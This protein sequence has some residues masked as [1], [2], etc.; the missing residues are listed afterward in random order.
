M[1]QAT[2][3]LV[4]TPDRDG[5]YPRLTDDQIARLAAEGRRRHVVAGEVLFREGDER[6]DFY[7][8]L[9]GRVAMVDQF[10]LP[11]ERVI[12]V[13]G[14]RRFLGE[15]GLLT[16]QAAFYTAVV[17]EP[18][19]VLVVPVQRLS[20]LVTQDVAL[21]DVVLRA[22][23]VRRELLIGLGAGFRVIGSRFSPDARR[24][25]E[26]AARNR[27][28][29]RWIDL[30]EDQAAE[31]LLR[32]L[33]VAPEETP[34]VIWNRQVLRNPSN[35]DLGREIGL[36]V[37][38]EPRA[39]CDL[40]VVG[41]GPAGLAAAVYGASEGLD[42]VVLDGVAT[43]GQA[44]TSS[45]IENYLG[46]PA[47]ISGA[48]LAERA[49]IQARKFGGRL[50]VPSEAVAAQP[51]DG[52][53]VVRLDDGA[54]ICAR[55]M[56]VATG[57][58]YRR[59]D[60]PGLDRLEGDSVYYAATLMEARVCAGD[61]VAVVG[62]GNSAGQAALFL[63]RYA[64]EVHVLVRGHSLTADMS[65]Y[66]A[67]RIA[68]EPRVSVMLQTEIRELDGDATLEAVIAEDRARGRR[69]RIPA[70][71]LFVFIGAE[72]HT[73]WLGGLVAL[74]PNGFVL[75]GADARESAANG[76]RSH[77]RPRLLLETS[78]PGVLAVGDVRSG[79][80]KRVASAVGEGAMAV[81]L[82]HEHLDRLHGHPHHAP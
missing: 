13:H 22:Y 16:G 67:D 7:V 3:Q 79:S 75:T 18:G 33:G 77:S 80:I 59:L 5:A 35:E 62:G 66:L 74:D 42:T 57:A 65:R 26:F 10:G 23:I 69:V 34:V 70:R 12:A 51:Q 19:E 31:A 37:P 47:G 53:Y 36:P 82:V 81:R 6:Y 9:R 30:E 46:F 72:P 49:T 21:A 4:E 73:D 14:E 17:S 56:V 48:E 64:T 20:E 52:H 15:L 38:R 28:P 25:R 45:K 40:L 44:G 78:R 58:R 32:E 43:G 41:A 29:H 61:P 11:E 54:E 76:D 71:A 68:R 1:T 2:E 50:L 24:L 8:V 39:V 27:L 55:V 60:V 63:A